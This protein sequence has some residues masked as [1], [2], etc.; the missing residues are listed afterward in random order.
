MHKFRIASGASWSMKL[1]VNWILRGAIDFDIFRAPEFRPFLA[2]F[3]N[4]RIKSDVLLCTLAA[5]ELITKITTKASTSIN[6]KILSTGDWGN[7]SW[8]LAQTNSEIINCP[9]LPDSK[10]G[11]KTLWKQMLAWN[12]KSCSSRYSLMAR[13]I[14][15]TLWDIVPMSLD[16]SPEYLG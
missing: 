14:L 10:V 1:N 9:E 7:W 16:V 2:S 11:R 15:K 12:P 8:S 3:C 13:L 6:G 4:F 5:M